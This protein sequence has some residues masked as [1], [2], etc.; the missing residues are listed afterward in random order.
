MD[1]LKRIN[2]HLQQ[3][4]PHIEQREAAVLLRAAMAEIQGQC[5]WQNEASGV[6]ARFVNLSAH[7]DSEAW[8]EV[9]IEATRLLNVPNKPLGVTC[10]VTTEIE[11]EQPSSINEVAMDASDIDRVV[12][13][14]PG[15]YLCCRI[16]SHDKPCEEAFQ[17]T[18]ID[19]DARGCDDP[20]KIPAYNGTDGD[21]YTHGKN[22]RV[23]DGYIKRDLGT[24][25]AWAVEV[26][27]I[28]S[29]VDKY[30]PCLISRDDNGFIELE[31]Y[32]YCGD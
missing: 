11:M 5:H 26:T 19:T 21:W 24:R 2:Q 7:P 22:H 14:R 9:A 18:V 25:K 1:L 28:F 16:E 13:S 3:L 4:A 29:F 12:K 8:G 6:M 20:K 31:I 23:E 27:D 32:S 15:L 17:I 30:G 10:R